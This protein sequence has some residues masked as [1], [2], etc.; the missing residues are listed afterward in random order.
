[1]AGFNLNGIR[2]NVVRTAKSGVVNQDTVFVFHQN[3]DVVTS[4]YAG[5]QVIKGFFVGRLDGATLTFR[6]CQIDKQGNLDG[7]VSNCKL[8][9]LPDGRL[10][11][12]ESFKWESR[13]AK[14]ENVFEELP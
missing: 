14:G 6:Y 8:S 5:G 12:V 4:E 2:M 11:M 1:M 3:K 7:G 10:S 9:R 13:G